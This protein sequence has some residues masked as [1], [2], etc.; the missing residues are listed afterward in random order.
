MSLIKVIRFSVSMLSRKS[1]P[2]ARSAS[3]KKDASVSSSV[4]IL[5]SKYLYISCTNTPVHNRYIT[6]PIRSV[7]TKINAVN[8]FFLI[9]VSFYAYFITYSSNSFYVVS[10]Y[11]KL[12]SKCSYMY[13]YS[14][15]FNFFIYIPNGV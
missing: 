12:L 11:A 1:F 7:L 4:K 5:L 9:I 8:D 14:S 10:I 3:F 13:I 2:L 6:E 15:T